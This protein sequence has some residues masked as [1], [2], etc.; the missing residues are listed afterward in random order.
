MEDGAPIFAL[1][2]VSTPRLG[3]IPWAKTAMTF[4]DEVIVLLQ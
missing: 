1:A 2:T 3:S 4:L